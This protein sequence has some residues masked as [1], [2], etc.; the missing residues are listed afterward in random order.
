MT[1]SLCDKCRLRG[2]YCCQGFKLSG[3]DKMVK[4]QGYRIIWKRGKSIG[5]EAWQTEYHCVK[6]GLDGRCTIYPSRPHA[7]KD[8]EPGHDELCE[9]SLVNLTGLA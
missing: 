5:G 8:Y 6:M 9:L 1:E 3:P 7:C 2:Y 4:S